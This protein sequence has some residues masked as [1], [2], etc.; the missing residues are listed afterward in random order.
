[1]QKIE[2]TPKTVGKIIDRLQKMTQGL[3]TSCFFYDQKP[4]RGRNNVYGPDLRGMA[5]VSVHSASKEIL[6][7]EKHKTP[8]IHL[9]ISQVKM[10]YYTFGDVFYFKG[11]QVI[12][13]RKGQYDVNSAVFDNFRHVEKITF[14]KSKK[15]MSEEDEG[16]IGL[17]SYQD[18]LS[19]QTQWEDL[20]EELLE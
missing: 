20:E 1:M 3:F 11:N 2:L 7:P 12:I 13:D 18:Q 6:V 8:L 17:L 14:V 9:F 5:K 15:Q 10:N 19:Y 16:L 4:L